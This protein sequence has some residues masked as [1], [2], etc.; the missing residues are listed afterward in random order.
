MTWS[1]HAFFTKVIYIFGA[2]PQRAGEEHDV[3]AQSD[4]RLVVPTLDRLL[5]GEQ[6]LRRLK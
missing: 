2:P 3:V 5:A 4:G 1:A 6:K